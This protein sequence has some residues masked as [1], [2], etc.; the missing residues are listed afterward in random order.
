MAGKRKRQGA[1]E[2]RPERRRRRVR[3]GNKEMIRLL[4]ERVRRGG[5]GK[6]GKGGEEGEGGEEGASM[7]NFC[8]L[9]RSL[10]LNTN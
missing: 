3:E 5:G 9:F 1:I 8:L 6:G 4:R 2:T 10:E 7:R